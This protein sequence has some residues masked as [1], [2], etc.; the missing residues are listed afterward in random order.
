MLLLK[1]TA[2]KL[3]EV[4]AGLADGS[5]HVF[6]TSTFTVDGKHLDSYLADVDDMGDYEHRIQ[7]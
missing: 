5:I 7:R 4:K 1:G 6:D 3:E 2:E